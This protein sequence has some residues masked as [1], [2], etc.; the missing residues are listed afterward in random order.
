MSRPAKNKPLLQVCLRLPRH[1]G[2]LTRPSP[3]I[4]R[5]PAGGRALKLARSSKS[6]LV[7]RLTLCH[8]GRSFMETSDLVV[9]SVHAT[10][11]YSTTAS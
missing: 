6:L 4:P 2:G 8:I 9:P 10:Q 11:P 5:M 3:V 7:L 1:A